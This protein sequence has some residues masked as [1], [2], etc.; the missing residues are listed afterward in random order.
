MWIWPDGSPWPSSG[1]PPPPPKRSRRNCPSQSRCWRS[2]VW[3]RR[4]SGAS[5]TQ[6]ALARAS[7]PCS[8]RLMR[9]QRAGG[10]P[11]SIFVYCRACVRAC[12]QPR[13]VD[14]DRRALCAFC[15]QAP[16][17]PSLPILQS[18]VVAVFPNV[19][20]LSSPYPMT[21]TSYD[22]LTGIH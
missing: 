5:G 2:I 3:P 8:F 15:V 16:R 10:P 17:H 14:S 20:P 22:S 9:P 19:T 12:G 1:R 7:V 13:S 18:A 21:P 6:E 4:V 11:L